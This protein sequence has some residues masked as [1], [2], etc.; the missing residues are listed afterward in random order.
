MLQCKKL[1][2]FLFLF[3]FLY[4]LEI[5]IS[6]FKK[7]EILTLYND[8]PFVCKQEKKKVICAFNK[9]PSTP[10]FKMKSLYF[11]VTPYFKKKF[12]IVI[13]IKGDF[14][15]KPFYDNLYNRP[16]ITPFPI[17]KAKK[18]IISRRIKEDSKGLNFYFHNSPKPFIGA[19][20]EKGNPLNMQ[21]SEDVLKYFDILKAFKAGR[22]VSDKI[23]NF[24]ENYPKSIFIPDI[25]YLKLNILFQNNQYDDVIKIGKS[26]IKNYAFNEKLPKVL[27]LI[28]RSYAAEGFL[29]DA[30]Y[31][32]NRIITEYPKEDIGYQAMIYLADQLF[33]MGDSK[34]AFQLYKMALA[35]SQN[36]ETAS[37]ASMR[38]ADRYIEKG[39]IKN[40]VFYYEK[41]Y[42]ANK[43][44]ILRDKEKA[45]ELAKNLAFNG[46]Y[47]LAIRI[48]EDILKRLKKLDDLYEPLLYNLAVWAYK[49][50]NYQLSNKFIDKYLKMF[51]YGDYS[52]KLKELQTKVLFEVPDKNISKELERIDTVLKEYN[53]TELANKALYKKV[54]ILYK[55]KKYQDILD[56]EKEIL[57][58]D[59]FK[60]KKQFLEKVKRDYLIELLNNKKC[61]EFSKKLKEYK[62]VLDKKF[63]EKI[64]KCAVKIKNYSLA[65]IVCN[66]YL[67]SPDDKVFVKWMKRKIVALKGLRDYKNLVLAIDDL[68]RVMRKGCYP[69]LL[70]KFF[71]LW[72]LQEY[73]EAIAL[74]KK[75]DKVQDIRNTDAF[76]K[77]VNYAL[78]NNDNLLAATFAKKIIDLQEKFNAYPYSPFVEF[79]Y[80]KYSQNRESNIKVLKNLLPRVKGENR[81]RAL[82]MLANLT[83]DKKYIDECLK[84][85]NSTLW[86]GLC[87]DAEGLF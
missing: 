23:D 51:P 49:E 17:K 26:W 28:A 19:I 27:L 12:Y 75:L 16:L 70:D 37:L 9:R 30:S 10:V 2:F 36:I 13:D 58:L 61:F 6:Y 59:N 21:K 54:M 66:K 22:D 7:G 81:A 40:A 80:A 5:N 52:D 11:K 55:Q 4:S 47:D 41:V 84:V 15:L 76:I 57:A 24:L 65:S 8:F 33:S 43:E 79:T 86:K 1:I 35:N 46:A 42:K 48:G 45:F 71:A 85:K 50:K 32:Y 53:G 74:A 87:K 3:S 31:F 56:L 78:K 77:I 34:K 20:D 39:D 73:K 67:D 14:F 64:Y 82:F 69:Y 38:L 25:L 62:I 63:D 18:W 44:Y 68:C 29:S 60:D 72:H 83:K